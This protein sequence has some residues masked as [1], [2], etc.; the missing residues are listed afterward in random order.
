M[1]LKT[2]HAENLA[3]AMEL[4]RQT[5][6]PNAIIVATHEDDAN[7]GARITAAVDPEE[8]PF[9]FFSEGASE[10]TLETLTRTLERHRVPNGLTDRLIDAAADSG[11][12][13]TEAVLR[14]ALDALFDFAPLPGAPKAVKTSAGKPLM[15]VG[16][17]GMGKT[18]ACAKIAAR[19]ALAAHG[20]GGTPPVALI[21]ADPVRLGASEQL[22]AYGD[23]LGVPVFDASDGPALTKAMAGVP[24]GVLALID[25]PGTNPYDL[26]DLAH[27]IE[28]KEAVRPEV[29]LVLSAGYDAD[30]AADLAAAFRP[31]APARL[32]ATGA[33][34]TRRLG[35]VLAAADAGGMQLTDISSAPEIGRGLTPLDGR[36]LAGLLLPDEDP[37]DKPTAGEEEGGA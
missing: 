17:P 35:A 34:M 5:L 6:G 24:N 23:R 21:S 9:D 14:D 13:E 11:A 25:T 36:T 18:A 37:A 15:L 19:L 20:K 27:L 3:A 28:L 33:D 4:V 7:R 1:R 30:E 10:E 12:R 2:F 32:L 16:P 29:V 8:Q 26:D 31:L 22:H